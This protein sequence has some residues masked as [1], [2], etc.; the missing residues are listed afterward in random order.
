MA[1][2]VSPA[3]QNGQEMFLYQYSKRIHTTVNATL[4]PKVNVHG[5]CLSPVHHYCFNI[6]GG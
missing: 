5:A 2:L 1:R 4:Q 6:L 3:V